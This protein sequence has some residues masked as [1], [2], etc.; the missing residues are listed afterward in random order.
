MKFSMKELKRLAPTNQD[1]FV[2]NLAKSRMQISGT[3][4]QL[5]EA[6]TIV[7]TNNQLRG[8]IPASSAHIYDAKDK[9][10]TTPIKLG[11]IFNCPE[12]FILKIAKEVI[13]PDF[14]FSV[15]RFTDNTS[16]FIGMNIIY[17]AETDAKSARL[18]TVFLE[19]E[20]DLEAAL[21]T[22][23]RLYKSDDTEPDEGGIYI[24]VKL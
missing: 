9:F 1:I 22:A 5:S 20:A 2:A 19:T 3:Q 23:E 24:D 15:L 6:I 12:T 13:V 10:T 7:E 14:L 4:V 8:F 18:G 17:F 16:P 11:G 21:S